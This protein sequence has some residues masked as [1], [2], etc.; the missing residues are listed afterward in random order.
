MEDENKFIEE[1]KA[2]YSGEETKGRTVDGDKLKV[3]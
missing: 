3:A 2:K 1:E